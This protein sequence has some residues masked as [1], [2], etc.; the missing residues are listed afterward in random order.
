MDES[1]RILAVHR[2]LVAAG[3]R[4]KSR[5]AAGVKVPVVARAQAVA[6][7]V[8]VKPPPLPPNQT[9]QV[10]PPPL[11][12]PPRSNRAP[13][14]AYSGVPVAA[15]GVLWR[16]KWALVLVGGLAVIVTAALVD[17][18]YRQIVSGTPSPNMTAPATR[19]MV[20]FAVYFFAF[21]WMRWAAALNSGFRFNIVAAALAT[22]IFAVV[23][24]P[25]T[26]YIFANAGG[27]SLWGMQ[28]NAAF[29]WPAAGPFGYPVLL[30]SQEQLGMVL[31]PAFTALIQF[32]LVVPILPILLHDWK[33]WPLKCVHAV[34]H[35][36]L[37]ATAIALAGGLAGLAVRQLAL[38]MPATQAGNTLASTAAIVSIIACLQVVVTAVLVGCLWRVVSSRVR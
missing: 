21:T 17:F 30:G 20:A 25:V 29:V 34:L 13:A 15:L 3:D 28:A 37:F 27:G 23:S 11:P 19:I 24:R 10:R 33:Q 31:E 9:P 12:S 18:A 22:T 35:L 14:L 16:E 32:G 6:P 4:A 1:E 2:Q 8:S 7:G 5:L 38:T 36:P 26:T